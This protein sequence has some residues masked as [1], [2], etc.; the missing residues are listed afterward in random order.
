MPEAPIRIRSNALA[1]GA[2]TRRLVAIDRVEAAEGPWL[3]SIA[4]A[5]ALA[6]GAIHL[7]QVGIHIDQGWM[8]AAFFIVVGVVQVGAAAMLLAPRPVGW[9]WFG[10]GGSGLIVAIWIVSRS[11]GLPFGAERGRPEELGTA[12]AAATLAEALT[13]VALSLA[14]RLRSHPRDGRAI[15][16]A[17]VLVLATGALWVGARAIGIFA[18]DPRLTGGP[19]DLADRAALL[20]VVGVAGLLALLH[21]GP[22]L[23]VLTWWRRAMLGLVG[24]VLLS[25]LALVVITLPARGGQNADCQYGPLAEVSGLSHAGVPPPAPLAAG[26]QRW[27]PVLVLSACGGDPVSL[28]GFEALHT[29]GPGGQI[30][31]VRV[32]PAGQKLP[33]AGAADLPAG[34]QPMADQPVIVP[35]EGARQVV[36]LVR[37]AE[38]TFN[39]D[40]VRVRYRF[41]STSGQFGYATFLGTCSPDSCAAAQH[42]G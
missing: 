15:G 34:S 26:A 5:L 10:I 29:R 20:L 8:F 12:D 31:D 39:L 6:S 9:F 36:V 28:S 16:I 4:A 22:H 30:V 40:A 17:I 3:R 18:P 23:C 27:L 24:V 2:L 13:I 1:L 19:P 21:R 7:A 35:G 41:G 11:L 32:L 25:S 42:G 38:G 14:L 37:G 33:S